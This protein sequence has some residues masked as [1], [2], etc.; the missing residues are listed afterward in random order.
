MNPAL[1]SFLATAYAMAR[2]ADLNAVDVG[3]VSLTDVPKQVLGFQAE[4]VRAE[5]VELIHD[6]VPELQTSVVTAARR[7]YPLASLKG[8]LDALDS[9]SLPSGARLSPEQPP[10]W[11]VFDS[12]GRG[13]TRFVECG[14]TVHLGKL[15]PADNQGREVWDR[16]IAA[17]SRFSYASLGRVVRAFLNGAD[18][19]W[20]YARLELLAPWPIHSLSAA[21][22]GTGLEIDLRM[23][24]SVKTSSLVLNLERESG[25]ERVEPNS[26]KWISSSHG[27]SGQVLARGVLRSAPR[28]TT[29]VNVFVKDLPT[30]A[31]RAEVRREERLYFPGLTTRPVEDV[32]SGHS[33]LRVSKVSVSDYRLIAHAELDFGASPVAVLAGPNQSGKS[34]LLDALALL[35]AV[36]HGSLR[37]AVQSRGALG[38]L[39]PRGREVTGLRLSLEAGQTPEKPEL[40]YSVELRPLGS[41]DYDV[42][43]ER[44]ERRRSAENWET[45]LEREGSR[46]RFGAGAAW[47]EDLAPPRESILTELTKTTSALRDVRTML[48]SIAVYP[49]FE[50]GAAWA[51]EEPT[52]ARAAGKMS[53][54][55]RLAPTGRNLVSALHAMHEARPR[56]FKELVQFMRLV[57]PALDD[58]R[59]E[60]V[61]YGVARLLWC[62][63]DSEFEQ[64]ELSDG[65]LALL[66]IGWALLDDGPSLVAIDEPEQ[67]LHP[68][69]L[70]RML[71][72]AESLAVR[73]P[74]LLVTQSDTLLGLMDENLAGIAIS[75]RTEA[76][77]RIV[78]PPLHE[79]KQWLAKYS[80]RDLRGELELWAP[81]E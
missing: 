45:L 4:L 34:T 56:D 39:L 12:G 41:V 9:G 31:L 54:G 50:T 64:S 36:G 13:D 61:G 75:Q 49:Y 42:A 51:S 1:D 71:G 76:G 15:F 48:A 21:F 37:R 25:D 74:I 3:V 78:R 40:R 62:E 69:A 20:D 68:D 7:Q 47:A 66:A 35:G 28:D 17:E 2:V 23:L 67:H 10:Q 18:W 63:K 72:L 52:G 33:A 46:F 8:L 38:L 6:T 60:T 5:S 43:L 19:R 53:P 24:D 22:V 81:A 14:A 26:F 65:T 11:Q 59:F 32:A 29:A 57:F 80:L 27:A 79:L 16:K 58:L 55:V 30:V 73:H 44:V 77:A 70:L